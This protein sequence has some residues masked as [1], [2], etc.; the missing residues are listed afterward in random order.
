M[1]IYHICIS[2]YIW[3]TYLIF[4]NISP[5]F[6]KPKKLS[7]FYVP[8]VTPWYFSVFKLFVWRKKHKGKKNKISFIKAILNVFGL[9]FHEFLPQY[10]LSFCPEFPEIPDLNFPAGTGQ[11]L[12]RFRSGNFRPVDTLVPLY[13]DP[14]VLQA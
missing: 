9:L 11:G 12:S 7:L 2:A 3:S 5:L 10:R 6:S 4:M 8:L 1:H 14:P 13:L